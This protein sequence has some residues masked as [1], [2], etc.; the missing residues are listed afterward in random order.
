MMTKQER[1]EH[2]A[3]MDSLTTEEEREAFRFEHHKEME[4]R[5]KER[6]VLV[7]ETPQNE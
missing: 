5:A 3:K 1:I 2:Q 7:P 6:G 4:L